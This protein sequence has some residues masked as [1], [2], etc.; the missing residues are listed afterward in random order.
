MAEFYRFVTLI[1]M[2]GWSPFLRV[3]ILL[4]VLAVVL[5]LLPRIEVE[6]RF[7]R[8]RTRKP[9]TGTCGCRDHGD[10]TESR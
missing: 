4:I 9:P 10:S 8:Q 5:A 7:R 6:V 2:A 1:S 3:V